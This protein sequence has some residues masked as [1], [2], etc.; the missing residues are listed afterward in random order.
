MGLLNAA[1]HGLG[2]DVFA[3]DLCHGGQHGNHQLTGFLGAVDTVLYADKIH[4]IILHGLQGGQHIRSVAP[5]AGQLEH[6]HEGHTVLAGLDILH[7][8]IELR[9]SLD[10]LAGFSGV[11]VLTDDLIPIEL[12]ICLDAVF[13]RVE[14]VTVGLH[15]GGDAGVDVDAHGG[16]G[17]RDCVLS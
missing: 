15:D 4:A 1:F 5:E 8:A 11:L 14:G 7:H 9:T 13:L 16:R 12:R 2:T 17:G 10:G 3:L 6:Q